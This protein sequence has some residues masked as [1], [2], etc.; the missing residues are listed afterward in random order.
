[1]VNTLPTNINTALRVWADAVCGAM[2]IPPY[3]CGGRYVISMYRYRPSMVGYM[4]KSFMGIFSES[5][6]F[7]HRLYIQIYYMLN[8][9]KTHTRAIYKQ[10]DKNYGIQNLSFKKS[11]TI[12]KVYT[13][14]F[15]YPRYSSYI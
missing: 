6:T 13:E 1:L 2:G 7:H 4:K 12:D 3:I 9:H 5:I 8:P 15:G 14:I 11:F 10:E